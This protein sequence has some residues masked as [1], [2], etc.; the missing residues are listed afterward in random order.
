MLQDFIP[1]IQHIS[2][3]WLNTIEITNTLSEESFHSQFGYLG[4]LLTDESAHIA[5]AEQQRL[6]LESL[7]SFF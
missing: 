3:V 2:G 4:R 1:K 6:T 5:L 7:V